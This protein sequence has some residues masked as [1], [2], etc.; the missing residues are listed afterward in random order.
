MGELDG[1][2][3]VDRLEGLGG[4]GDRLEHVGDDRFRRA[5][6]VLEGLAPP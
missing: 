4:L 2:G 1:I 3:P 5:A 6:H